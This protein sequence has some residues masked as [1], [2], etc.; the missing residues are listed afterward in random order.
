MLLVE[1]SVYLHDFEGTNYIPLEQYDHKWVVDHAKYNICHE[2]V[3]AYDN[4]YT[5]I[6]VSQNALPLTDSP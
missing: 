2:Y 4:D 6:E 3:Q 5:W 1:M